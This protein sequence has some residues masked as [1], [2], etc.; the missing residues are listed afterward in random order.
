MRSGAGPACAWPGIA[1]LPRAPARYVVASAKVLHARSRGCL[2]GRQPTD[3][4]AAARA[5]GPHAR[6][7]RGPELVRPSVRPCAWARR[8]AALAG[9]TRA[10]A[11]RTAARARRT[12]PRAGRTAAPRR[13]ASC[14]RPRR[15]PAWP[16][17][18]RRPSTS[19]PR[20]ARRRHR[21]CAALARGSRP[22]ARRS[23]D[24]VPHSAA[25]PRVM[26]LAEPPWLAQQYAPRRR[27]TIQLLLH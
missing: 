9:R 26:D 17:S 19:W 22:R 24:V 2:R 13:S 15:R 6:Q 20:P 3:V 16:W 23:A 4:P 8:T 1:S 18:A 14:S 12:A 21:S 27:V 11:R 5:A 10:R 25:S 7:G